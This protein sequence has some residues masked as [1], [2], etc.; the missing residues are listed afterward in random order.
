M[1]TVKSLSFSDISDNFLTDFS[2][3]QQITAKWE[4]S[5]NKWVTVETDVLREW[6]TEKRKW[7]PSYLREQTERGGFVLGA[8]NDD[9][10]VGFSSVDGI[11]LGERSK[12]ANLTMLF[13]DDRF[14]RKGIGTLLFH[15]IKSC[16]ADLNA[17]K[18]FISA[19][20]S[21]DTIAFYFSMGCSDADEIIPQFIDNDEDR[22]LE[23]PLIER[24]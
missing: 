20:P 7:I 23:F 22:C 24:T 6:D 13:V 19:I 2:H 8:F 4:K 15:C 21:V 14:K 10:L 16:A 1:I 17:E 11:L 9:E 5:N 12:Y 18:L 3:K